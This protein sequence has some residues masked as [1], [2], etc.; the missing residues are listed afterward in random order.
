MQADQASS[1][2]RQA[3]E[4]QEAYCQGC[5]PQERL[6]SPLCLQKTVPSLRWDGLLWIAVGRRLRPYERRS[7]RR[8]VG[9]A[10]RPGIG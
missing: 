8:R 9:E 7:R 1:V 5:R 4:A 6:L 3:Q 10:T 2:P